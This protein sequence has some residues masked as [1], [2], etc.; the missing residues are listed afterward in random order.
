MRKTVTLIV[1][2]I[3][4]TFGL[5]AQGWPSGYGGVMLQG[6]FWDSFRP[7]DGSPSQTM[8]TMYGAGW[9]ENDQWYLPV[10]TWTELLNQKDK[11]APYIDLLWLPQ[12]GATVC[13]DKTEFNTENE[14]RRAG[15]NGSWEVTHRGDLINNPDC[16]GFVPVFYLDHGRGQTYNINGKTWTPK[17]YFGTET[18]LINL[19]SAYKAAGT[20]AMED[21]VANHKGGLSTW[22]GVDYAADFVDEVDVTGPTTG[23]TYSIQWEWDQN[24]KCVDICSDD[25]SGKGSGNI[26]CG[27]DAGKGSWARDVD[28][29]SA[30]TQHKVLTYLRYLKDELGYIG[31]RYDYARGF[32][33]KH[34][35]YYNTTVR[36]TFSVGEFWG[37]FEDITDWIKG[38]YDEG[39]FQSAAFDFPLQEVIRQAFNDESGQSFRLLENDGLIWDY[40]YRRFAVTFIDNHDT[41]KDLPTDASNSNYMHRVNH[42]IVEANCFILAMPGTPC[43]FYPHFMHPDW[44]DIIARFV[45]ARRTAGITNESTVWPSEKTGAH[46]IS[47]RVTGEKGEL[48]LQLGSEAV[49]AGVP[50]GFSQVWCNTAGTCRLSITSSLADQV[51]SNEKQDLVYGYPVVSKSS[52]NYSAPIDVNVKP[53]SEGTVLVYTTD[54]KM[55]DPYSNQI[56]DTAGVDF[57]FTTATTLKVG[58]LANG[59]VRPNSIVTRDYVVD[60]TAGSGNIKVYVKYDGGDLPYLYAYDDNDN[61]LTGTFPGWQYSTA[62]SVVVGGVTWL[63]ATVPAERMNVILSYGGDATKTADIMG[64]TTDVFYTF[65]DNVAHDVTSVYSQALYNPIVSIDLASGDFEGDIS[66]RLTASNSNAVIVYTTDGSEPSASNGTQVTY[67][68]VVPFTGA[69]SHVLRAGVLVDGT[70]INQV[71]RTYYINNESTIEPETPADAGVSIYVHSATGAAPYIYSWHKPKTGEVKQTGDWPGTQMTEMKEVNGKQWYYYHFDSDTIRYIINNGSNVQSPDQRAIFAG[72]Y[73]MEFDAGNAGSPFENVTDDYVD[74]RSVN[75]QTQEPFPV[76]IEGTNFYVMTFGNTAY[77][78]AWDGDHKVFGNWP[79]AKLQQ[80]MGRS[81]NSTSTP[82]M[83]LHTDDDVDKYIVNGNNGTQTAD[84]NAVSPG[85]NLCRFN[86]SNNYYAPEQILNL[87]DDLR[88][89]CQWQLK[90]PQYPA[91]DQPQQDAVNVYVS[92][93]AAPFIHAWSGNTN[94]TTWPGQKLTDKSYS[95]NGINWY[96]FT[97]DASSLNIVLND[98]NGHQTANIEGLTPGDHY[99]VY[100]GLTGYTLVDEHLPSCIYNMGNDKFYCYFENSAPYGL[101]YAWIYNQ[102]AIYTGGCWPGEALVEAVGVAPNG[103][104][105]YRWTYTGDKVNA[106]ANVLFNDNGGNV[107]GVSQTPNF[108]FVNGGYYNADG[109]AGVADSRLMTLADVIR[110]GELNQQYVIANDLTTVWL[111]NTGEWLWVKD[112]GDAV[113][114]SLNTQGLPVPR[115]GQDQVYDQSNW[116]QLVLKEPAQTVDEV[117]KLSNKR[118]L[119]QTVVGVLTDR[120]NPTVKLK[121]SPIPT[122]SEQ[123]IPNTFYPANFIAQN[124]YFSVEPKP[125]EY[126]NINWAFCRR[127]IDDYTFEFTVPK[128]DTV[129]IV[130]GDREDTLYVNMEDLK[131]AF[132]AHIDPDYWNDMSSFGPSTIQTGYWYNDLKAIIKAIPSSSL[133]LKSNSY[134]PDNASPLSTSR[135]AYAISYAATG[136]I[137][138]SIQV[139]NR[140]VD[141]VSVDYYNLL[142]VRSDAPFEGINI[143]VTRYSDGSTSAFKILR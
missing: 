38:V 35:A 50:S 69:G 89:R 51:D 61:S 131:G 126:V 64:V 114:P 22:S 72:A 139:V 39:G 113:N 18:E 44:H 88:P 122:A 80:M 121:A 79:G 55:P 93:E 53:S 130:N 106:P 111:N 71:A 104:M 29:H 17:S 58:V 8:A 141:V 85:V 119:G 82:I 32:E 91:Q 143:V 57:S 24:G 84:L 36:P 123:Y 2:V 3:F 92:A 120:I 30:A 5:L 124:K 47:W 56:T 63:H 28:H 86:S 134:T 97:Q 26:D 105:I 94:Y 15:H 110:Y 135:E 52:G 136:G 116:A 10:T 127:R 40:R 62:N 100:N 34:F 76:Y 137:T 95:H 142:G 13:S 1:L 98:G 6:F 138:T 41:F 99:I 43:L 81:S 77:V 37:T 42:Q 112:D 125:Q 102:T 103:N 132:V 117:L 60:N 25:E 129:V 140:D 49:G 90:Y 74:Y 12:S 59:Q 70:V 66:P 54:G 78:Y 48:Y 27:G 33:P 107:V 7:A 23:K 87:P 16:M 101:P 118:L 67:Q 9:G 115:V 73:F 109:L 65:A 46:G 20:G 31:F 96:K 83:Y 128:K 45:K 4:S 68:G 75:P 133:L 11:I 108:T 21:V 14:A 19:I